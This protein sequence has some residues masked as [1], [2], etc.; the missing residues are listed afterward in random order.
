MLVQHLRCR[1]GVTCRIEWQNCAKFELVISIRT[2][3]DRRYISSKSVPKIV[4]QPCPQ[5]A[6]HLKLL[7]RFHC[8]DWKGASIEESSSEGSVDWGKEWRARSQYVGAGPRNL[9]L[10]L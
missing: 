7:L 2:K 4:V 1:K 9:S 10:A 3:I 6:S 8:R 5:T